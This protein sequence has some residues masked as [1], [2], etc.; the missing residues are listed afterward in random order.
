MVAMHSCENT[1]GCCRVDVE[2]GSSFQFKFV[3]NHSKNNI[4]ASSSQSS[5]LWDR[6]S[7][8]SDGLNGLLLLWRIVDQSTRVAANQ[9]KRNYAC[10]SEH[11]DCT[12]YTAKVQPALTGPKA[13]TASAA[14]AIQATL[15]FH[16]AA[17][18]TE[19]TLFFR[20]I[21]QP[22]VQLLSGI[23]GHRYIC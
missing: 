13:T 16:M 20:K 15:T 22:N 2:D 4:D 1:S 14:L 18:T 5:P 19:V 21:K 9:N 10:V 3:Y 8:T 17:P 11:A 23:F 7:I 6:I 12:D